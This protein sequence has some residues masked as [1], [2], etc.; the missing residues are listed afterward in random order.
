MKLQYLVISNFGPFYGHR[1]INFRTENN[2]SGYAFFAE[3]NRG[4]TSIYNSLRW[5]LFG[6]V[7]ERAKT[8]NGQSY[9]GGKIPIV[10]SEGKILMNDTAYSQDDDAEMSVMIFAEGKKGNIQI[11]RNAKKIGKLPRT[12]D[13]VKI[14][15]EVKVGDNPIATGKE[16][17]ELIESFF[18]KGIE[19]FFFI[20][21]EALE[22]YTEMMQSNSSKGLTDSVNQILRIPALVKGVDD[23]SSIRT[24][25]KSNIDASIKANDKT[26][27]ANQQAENQKKIL[28]EAT[29]KAEAKHKELKL[30]QKELTEVQANISKHQELKPLVEKLKK[31]EGNI[32]LSESL[33]KDYS[34]D[35]MTESKE[36]WKVLIWKKAS[37]TYSSLDKLQ[38]SN[39]ELERTKEE[40]RSKISNLSRDLKELSDLCAECRQPLPDIDAHRGRKEAELQD[41]KNSLSILESKNVYSNDELTIKLGDL[42]KL[43]PK[44]DALERI[45]RVQEKWQKK[46]SE[47]INQKEEYIQLN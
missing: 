44:E 24:K 14:S 23:L 11:T 28:R 20:D 8:V 10:G 41:Y 6:E 33:L 47:L 34:I 29:K 46:L 4:K 5:C 2:G 25:V 3:N 18:P 40:L 30:I 27:L 13:D 39:R 45:T 32:K 38:K 16:A 42:I 19:R 36:A 31:V 21:G 26:K 22:E 17:S 9:A 15:L 37:E 1:T 12:D 7:L 35:K 43:K